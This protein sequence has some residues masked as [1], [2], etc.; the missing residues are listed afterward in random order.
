MLQRE[1]EGK[2]RTAVCLPV[3]PD[4]GSRAALVGSRHSSVGK[5]YARCSSLGRLLSASV[6]AVFDAR[7]IRLTP[8]SAP[9]LSLLL[10]T[11]AM[12]SDASTSMLVEA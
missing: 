12:I 1:S 4:S 6:A 10:L 5:R 8:P 9:S 3:N 11:L 7:L 2:K